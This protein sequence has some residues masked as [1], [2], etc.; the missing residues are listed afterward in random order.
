VGGRLAE[1][2]KDAATRVAPID[3]A[4]ARD[5]IEAVRG[6]ASIR[7]WR[8]QAVGDLEGLASMIVALSRL[9]LIPGRPISEAEINPVIV[10]TDRVTAV[11]GLI[12]LK[13]PG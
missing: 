1:L 5:M 8:G 12:V 6:L 10:L 9:A 4:G 7:G 11:D 2:Y 3:L 13:S